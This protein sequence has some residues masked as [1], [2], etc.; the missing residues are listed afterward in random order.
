MK[1]TLLLVL[2]LSDQFSYDV[3]FLVIFC[4]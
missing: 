1:S 3:E 2:V 4:F